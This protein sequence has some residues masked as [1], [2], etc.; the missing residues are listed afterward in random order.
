[1]TITLYTRKDTGGL[2]VEAALAK[3]AAPHQLIQI[4]TERGEQNA[5]DFVRINPM[6]QIPAIV[7]PDGTLMTESAAIVMHLADLFPA[8]GLAPAPATPARARFLRWML[9]MATNLYEPDL[10][11]FY[12]ERYTSDPAGAVG[13]K[14]AAVS[15][16]ARCFAVIE[17]ALDPFVAGRELSI[18]DAY[19][20]MLMG[21]SPEPLKSAKLKAVLTA[22]TTDSDYGP[23]WAR[24]GLI[25]E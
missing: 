7:F 15:H 17:A 16:M 2:V 3:A 14:S 8:K 9:Y 6:R 19:L 18:A 22:V 12:P 5:P 4:D 11:Y 24:H 25:H 13:I 23:V 1:M 21:W 10:R 20:A